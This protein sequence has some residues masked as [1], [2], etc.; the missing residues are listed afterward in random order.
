MSTV[1]YGFAEAYVLRGLHKKK[2]KMEQEE[3]RVKLGRAESEIGQPSGCLFRVMK[4][5]HPSNAQSQ[6]ACSAETEETAEVRAL[7]QKVR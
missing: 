3:E 4:K 1:G 5:V 2:L 6:R 7:N